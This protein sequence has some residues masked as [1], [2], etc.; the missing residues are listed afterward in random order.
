MDGVEWHSVQ[1]IRGPQ[2]NRTVTHRQIEPPSVARLVR[3][4]PL[5]DRT[6]PVCIRLELY[7]CYIDQSSKATSEDEFIDEYISFALIMVGAI[8]TGFWG[9]IFVIHV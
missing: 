8:W 3:L 1:V 2:R 7:G 5:T 6:M 4:I 9:L